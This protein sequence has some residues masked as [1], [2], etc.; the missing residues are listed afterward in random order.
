MLNAAPG[1]EKLGRPPA[2]LKPY[3]RSRNIVINNVAKFMGIVTETIIG[4]AVLKSVLFA[5]LHKTVKLSLCTM[6]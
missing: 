6:P 4:V 2:Q 3:E 1:S 5:W